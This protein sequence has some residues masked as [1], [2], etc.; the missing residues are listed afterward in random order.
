[1]TYYRS[2]NDVLCVSLH[3]RETKILP[4]GTILRP[5]NNYREDE[6]PLKEG[7]LVSV[8]GGGCYVLL[9][10]LQRTLVLSETVRV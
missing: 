8:K 9:A 1:M 6:D 7:V 2:D 4:R 10:P 5:T 3:D